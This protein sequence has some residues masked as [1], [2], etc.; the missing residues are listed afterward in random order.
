[1]CRRQFVLDLCVV[2]DAALFSI[3]Q[4]HSA[5]L[6]PPF[7]HDLFF[8]D[9]QHSRLRSKDDQPVLGHHIT[10]R[11]QAVAVQRRTDLSPICE[12]HRGRPIPRLHQGS[13]ILVERPVL[14]IHQTIALPCLGN[15]HHGRVGE[16]VS[17]LY[18]QLKGVV[19]TRRIG[20]IFV[21]EWPDLAEII[22]QDLRVHRGAPSVHPVEISPQC[23]DF[24]VVNDHSKRLC[25]PPTRKGVRRETL[26]NQC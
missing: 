8:R 7:L 1:M 2:D 6:Q 9:L 20:L 21:D 11:P 17:S 22:A 26:V 18:Q 12:C 4:Q 16:G 5:R 15:Q 25:E 23:V 14:R 3:T 10:G 13:V 19:E 24:A